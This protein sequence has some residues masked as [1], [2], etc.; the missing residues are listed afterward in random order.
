MLAVLSKH[1]SPELDK[2][3]R[4][5][6]EGRGVPLIKAGALGFYSGLRYVEARSPG[7]RVLLRSAGNELNG[8]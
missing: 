6:Y 1:S 5:G 8:F 3:R 4:A 2:R 7:V